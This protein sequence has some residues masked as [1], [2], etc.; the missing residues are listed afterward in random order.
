MLSSQKRS[1]IRFLIIYLLSTLILFALA[2]WLF[3]S[4]TKAHLLDQQR[5]ILL[6]EAD[7]IKS[8]LRELHQSDANRL[9]YPQS[10]DVKSAIYDLDREYIF[11][12]LDRSIALDSNQDS[13]KIYT[14]LNIEPYYLGA[15]YLLVTKDIDF[16][17][18][19]SLEK[20]IFIFMLIAALFFTILGYYL[21]GLFIAPMRE[22]IERMNYFI[23]DATHELNTP[24]S[25]ILTNIE[26]IESLDNSL[27][28][29]QELRRIEVAS[30]TLSRIYDDLAYLNLNHNYHRH[31][32]S[33]D[34]SSLI[35]E[36][37]EY[38]RALAKAKELKIELDI[39]RDIVL[40]IDKNDALR[41]CDNLISNAIKY[42][43]IGGLLI[44]RV[45]K[46]TLSVEDSGVGIKEEDL[47]FILERFRRA[48][49][50]EGGFGIG[51]NI[52]NHVVRN[53]GFELKIESKENQGTK[54]VIVW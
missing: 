53:Y 43:K 1:L 54:V 10:K 33:I 39:K 15:A 32:E 36:R 41:L 24:I 14:V 21:G 48:N 52:V 2:S 3:Y 5:D 27:K 46:N 28:N 26:M 49:K 20:R 12:T 8:Q 47:L 35:E 17:P 23:Q 29:S 51:L 45:D 16:Q 11:G 18:I 13:S 50:S 34:I 40:E 42:N 38:F 4:F 9:F 7:H 6:Y 19:Y 44:I 22:A 30:K 25:T 37:V 31:I